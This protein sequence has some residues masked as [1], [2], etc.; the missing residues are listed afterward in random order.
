[1]CNINGQSSSHKT[2]TTAVAQGSIL[3][4]LLFLLYKNDLPQCLF[5]TTPCLY[6]DD[7]QIFASS[8][9]YTDLLKN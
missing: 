7:I 3:R 8:I 5:T 4:P 2:I 6:A 1:M 9:D